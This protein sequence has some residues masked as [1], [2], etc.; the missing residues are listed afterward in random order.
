[1][2][3]K[4]F[5]I[6]SYA[7]IAANISAQTTAFTYQGSL[8]DGANPA[9]GNYDFEFKLFDLVSG[10]TQQGTTV[11][12][13]NVAVANGTF[14]VSLDFGTAV[15]TGADRFLDVAVRTAGG[16]AFTAL[17]PR[18]K[19]NSAPYSV[20]SLNSAAA[21]SA[22]NAT[23]L[24]G[25]A[26]NQY[27]LTGDPR[28]TDS[29]PP[30]AGSSNYIQNQS[31]GPQVGS[32]F[33]ISGSAIVGSSLSVGNSNTSGRL[34]LNRSTP[35]TANSSD[36]NF[37]SSTGP[38]F[39]LG[40][41]Q[42]SAPSTDFSLYNYGT[43]SN[44]L[45]VQR[46]TGRIGFGT[47]SPSY[48]FHF[49]S[50]VANT[51]AMHVQTNGLSQGQSYGLVVSAG[52]SNGGDT[53]FWTRAQDGTSLLRVRG[54]GTVGIG[55]DAPGE[56]LVISR[57][58]ASATSMSLENTSS[59]SSKKLYLSNYGVNGGGIYWSGLDSANTSSLYA[60][61][62]LILRAQGGL[63]FS[64]SSTAEHM[65][66]AANG[67]VGIGAGPIGSVRLYVYADP[68]QA[69]FSAISAQGL[70]G[71][72]GTG[73]SGNGV[74]GLSTSGIGVYAESTNGIPLLV[75]SG[76]TAANLVEGWNGP[77]GRRFYINS[78]GTYTGGS[79]FA[80]ALPASGDRLAYEPGDVLIASADHPGKVAKTSRAYD[81]RV[82]GVYST[83]PGVIGAEK[84]GTSRVDPDDIAVAVVGI[85]PTKVT[86]YNGPVQIGD[87]LTT[88]SMP[89]Y[90]M[91]CSN[92]ARCIGA[93]VGK[94][95]EPLARGRSIIKV[96]VTIR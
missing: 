88:S 61:N 21:D 73:S 45:T 7:F 49:V 66:I 50:S 69:P 83:R 29:R 32:S 86:A 68:S 17:S 42:G 67:T 82:I 89:G 13:L 12:R 63:I 41:S 71:I 58:F 87:L 47:V 90:A 51:F 64:G 76:D 54:D 60:P 81:P 20:R 37:G 5:L 30:S 18:Q 93:V 39:S 1:M 92:K 44:V 94:A 2:R 34:F 38:D 11:Q 95:M 26:A 36:V 48:P 14:N 33:N 85:V 40:T 6:L 28:M 70:T 9:N 80:E 57:N 8:K 77:Q 23:Q 96:L 46:S 62:P 16:G 65:R 15:L 79:D 55:T 91:R 56:P 72:T 24:G 19:I 53:P 59:G 84:G 31:A 75:F 25:V 78:F 43:A 35:I 10:G 27:V 74:Q 3:K 22:T 52:T 4:F